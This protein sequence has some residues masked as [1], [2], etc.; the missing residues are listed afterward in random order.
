[1]TALSM[2][3]R[4]YFELRTKAHLVEN[5]S[6]GKNKMLTTGAPKNININHAEL[7]QVLLYSNGGLPAKP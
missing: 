1:M 4:Q 5:A 6:R 3:G 2:H 7:H